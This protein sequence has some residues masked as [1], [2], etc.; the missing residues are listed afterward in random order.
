MNDRSKG[1]VDEEAYDLSAVKRDIARLTQ[2]VTD[3]AGALGALAKRRAA[4]GLRQA[5][6]NVDTIMSDGADRAEAAADAARVTVASIED[7]LADAVAERP[8]AAVAIGF[9]V[10]LLIGVTWRR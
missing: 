5:Q 3:M 6:A 7:T 8:L 2:Q 4:R 1:A 9:G 10:G